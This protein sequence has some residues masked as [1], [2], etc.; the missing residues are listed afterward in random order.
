MTRPRR[1]TPSLRPPMAAPGMR[2]GLLGGTFDPPHDGHAQISR[3][4]LRR[5][6]LDRVWWLV[7]PGNPLKS[8]GAHAAFERRLDLARAFAC[9]PRIDVTGFEA[10]RPDAFTVNTLGFLRRRFPATRFVWLMGAD[11]LAGFHRWRDWR[12]I[13]RLAPV[14]VFDRPGYRLAA[15]ASQAASAFARY[16]RP[17]RAA[18]GLPARRPPAW[19]LVSMRLSPLSSTALR[20]AQSPDSAGTPLHRDAPAGY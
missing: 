5:L 1:A 8:A 14:A 10:A 9:H 4:A 11:N 16:R 15:Q 17:E 13:L 18:A 6:Q 12:R 3:T 2:I 20:A 7:T 19:A